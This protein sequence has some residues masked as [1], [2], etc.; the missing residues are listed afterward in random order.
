M[1]DSSLDE[2]SSCWR[3]ND[4]GS[5]FTNLRCETQGSEL[6]SHAVPEPKSAFFGQKADGELDGVSTALSFSLLRVVAN[7]VT[8]SVSD[9]SKHSIELPTGLEKFYLI[10]K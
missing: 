1:V 6:E 5:R 2:F 9:G 7:D 10:T 4:P 8:W 3:T